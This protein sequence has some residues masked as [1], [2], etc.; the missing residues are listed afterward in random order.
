MEKSLIE[1]EQ[2]TNTPDK[3]TVIVPTSG[4]PLWLFQLMVMSLYFRSNSDVVGVVFVVNGSGPEQQAKL[5]W[6]CQLRNMS[7]FPFT[8]ITVE[9]QVGHCQALDCAIPWV[10]TEF[11]ASFHD[12]VIVTNKA[13]S[14][15]VRQRFAD[16]PQL[17][18][19]VS[20][21]C[22]FDGQS[23][24]E[25]KAVLHKKHPATDFVCWRKS[26][27]TDTG[28]LWR[29]YHAPFSE[30]CVFSTDVGYWACRKLTEGGWSVEEMGEWKTHVHF[31][32]GSWSTPAHLSETLA[33]FST[34]VL[35]VQRLIGARPYDLH[36]VWPT[37]TSPTITYDKLAEWHD[38]ERMHVHQNFF[39]FRDWLKLLQQLQPTTLLE[40]G[41]YKWGT[42][43]MALS[44][45][46]SIKKLVTVDIENRLAERPE[47][48]AKYGGRLAFVCGDTQQSA[49]W[50]KID[51]ELG[52]ESVDIAFI[53][54]NHD[55][56]P[57]MFD[58][59]ECTRLVRAGGL[60]GIHDVNPECGPIGSVVAFRELMQ[61]F[62]NKAHMIDCSAEKGPWD[63]YGIGVYRCV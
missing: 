56:R 34:E 21:W 2:M 59:S 11:V 55:Y 24:W 47:I 61:E 35:E 1:L 49:T 31:V 63:N 28:A 32:A 13:W 54:G 30:N 33:K 5:H 17:G 45:I 48:L 57:T 29:G 22:G 60:I 44:A 36:C 43:Q 26:A 4:S 20:G 38:A 7:L 51:A 52:G 53:D 41:T 6:L 16:N 9:G 23:P 18:M 8:V 3:I 62:P 12:D 39:E 15:A 46:P 10:T 27:F 42:A 40:I 14:C 58:F 19:L 37:F 50:E 25:N